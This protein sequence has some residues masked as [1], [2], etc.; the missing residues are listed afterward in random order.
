MSPSAA[1]G[2]GSCSQLRTSADSSGVKSGDS[3]RGTVSGAMCCGARSATDA[4]RTMHSRA[5]RATRSGRG[6]MPMGRQR[7]SRRPS[8]RCCRLSGVVARRRKCLFATFDECRRSCFAPGDVPQ[9]RYLSMVPDSICVSTRGW[10][11]ALFEASRLALLTRAP[12]QIILYTVCRC[13]YACQPVH[14]QAEWRPPRGSAL[15]LLCRLSASI[16]LRQKVWQP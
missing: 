13:V 16:K 12:S 5:T 6:S 9:L 8:A 15:A 2:A 1:T 7:K 10:W 11:L 4:D 3:R 14:M